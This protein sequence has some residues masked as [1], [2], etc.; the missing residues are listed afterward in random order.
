MDDGALALLRRRDFRRLYIAVAVSELG[1]AF[2]YIALMWIALIRGGP[3]G[4][5]IVRLADSIPALVFG[6]H[7][8]IAADRWNRKRIMV[9]ADLARGVVLIPVAVAG[10]TGRLPLW[11]LA[12]AAFLLETATSYFAPAYSALM[13]ALVDRRNVQEANGLLGAT[14][15]ALS[16]GGWAAAAGLLAIMPT[17]AFFVLN[18]VSFFVSAIFIGSIRQAGAAVASD[19]QRPQLRETF[20]AFRLTPAL[21]LTVIVLGLAMTISSGTWI[22]GV[23]ELVRTVLHR[24][25]GGY[26]IVMVGYAV[27]SVAAGAALVRYPIRNKA[28][29][30]ML[31][32]T[33]YLFA[34]G[35]FAFGTSLTIAVA[36]AILAAASQSGAAIL[37]TSAAQEQ[38]ADDVLGRVMGVISLV[39]RGAHATGLLLISPLFAVFAPSTM[40]AGAAVAIPLI[41]ISGATLAYFGERR[42]RIESAAGSPA[43]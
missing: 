27:G 11:G 38:I 42:R 18:A 19:A 21:G 26:S 41:G 40:F 22:A 14:A 33:L 29:A 15:N 17:S 16:I 23:P 7:G 13:P 9:S 5:M 24:G 25:A 36:G 12:L 6:F 32:W 31:A 10:L 39:Y 34:Y 37:L 28:R 4:V 43:G 35:L 30:S 20:S 1:D 2:Q 3:I 8:G